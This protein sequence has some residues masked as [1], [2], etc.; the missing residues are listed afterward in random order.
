MPPLT[1][2]FDTAGAYLTCHKAFINTLCAGK[3][4]LRR[5]MLISVA[6]ERKKEYNK[7]NYHVEG[8]PCVF[9]G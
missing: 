2:V 3:T 9:W 1:V 4:F 5:Y 8:S 7:L 6:R